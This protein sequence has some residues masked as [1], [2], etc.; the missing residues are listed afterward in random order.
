MYASM[1]VCVQNLIPS[2]KI[3][4]TRRKKET[5]TEREKKY[6]DKETEISQNIRI[7]SREN[8]RLSISI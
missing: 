4:L 8:H 1:C 5:E 6:K 2:T 3:T 7:L